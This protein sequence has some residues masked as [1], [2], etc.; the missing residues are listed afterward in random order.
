MIGATKAFPCLQPLELH[1]VGF[2]SCVVRCAAV[3]CS[4]VSVSPVAGMRAPGASGQ[5][6]QEQH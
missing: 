4:F 5:Q 6:Q 2:L 3:W 1:P